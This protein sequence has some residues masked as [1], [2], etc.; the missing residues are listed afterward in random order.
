MEIPSKQNNSY[1]QK[2]KGKKSTGAHNSRFLL[3]KIRVSLRWRKALGGKMGVFRFW[4]F[5]MSVEKAVSWIVES[6]VQGRSLSCSYK[7][8]SC[9]PV[10]VI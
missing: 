5:E 1:K 8:R 10:R 6:V 9:Q 3:R 4:T 2:K 7:F